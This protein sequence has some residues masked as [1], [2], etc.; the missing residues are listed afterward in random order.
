MEQFDPQSSLKAFVS[1]VDGSFAWSRESFGL[2]VTTQVWQGFEWRHDV[3]LCRPTGPVS[4]LWTLHIT[5][6][7]P[8]EFDIGWSQSL[9]DL[10]GHNV[11]VL[12]QMPNQPLW[13]MTE[14]DLI[15]HTFVQFLETGDPAWPLLMPMVR[16]VVRVMD[17]LEQSEGR[18]LR[19]VPF[20]ASKRGWTSWLTAATQD[21]RVVGVAPMLF[22]HLRMSEQLAKQMEDWGELS[23]RI[24]DYTSRGL[25]NEVSTT[26]GRHLVQLVDPATFVKDIHVP[27]LLIHGSNDPYWTVDA[28]SLYWN[29]L[30]GLKWEVTVPNLAH[31]FDHVEFWTPTLAAFVRV[32]DGSHSQTTGVTVPWEAA[33]PDLRFEFSEWGQSAVM[34]Q[35]ARYEAVQHELDGIV[36]WLTSPVEVVRTQ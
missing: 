11:A 30:E 10:S 15:A 16:S 6:W 9:A 18:P 32:C 7:E 8:N 4:D 12:F 23:P 20:G 3:V 1:H 2:S 22:N 36:F 33:S 14:D 28:T 24:V 31:A 17:A 5:G 27:K 13:D 25:E 19:F 35:G 26:R 21:S 34:R 29:D